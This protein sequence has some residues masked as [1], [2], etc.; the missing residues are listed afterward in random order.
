MVL[1][2]LANI[3]LVPWLNH[4]GLALSIGL[5]ACLNAGMLWRGLSKLGVLK[6]NAGW[7]IFLFK[8]SLALIGLSIILYLGAHQHNWITLGQTPL[9]RIS[10][11]AGWLMVAG[12][13][14]LSILWILGF[15]TKNFLYK[16]E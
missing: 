1:T 4:A 16:T 10:L 12:V 7:L 15:R 3:V 2:Q 9:T 5:G 11:L 6:K 8:L 13:T 14:Y